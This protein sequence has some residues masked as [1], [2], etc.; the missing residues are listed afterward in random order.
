MTAPPRPVTRDGDRPEISIVVPVYN[1]E[2]GLSAFWA[3]LAPVLNS[4]A[5]RA[6]VVFIDD[7][8]SDG[9]LAQLVSLRHLDPRVRIV[10]LS[11][12]FG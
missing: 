9:T 4:F 8:S 7:G 12:N 10:S 2:T 6:E 5:H 1:E 11:R 3:R